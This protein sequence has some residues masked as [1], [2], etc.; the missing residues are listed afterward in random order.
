MRVLCPQCSAEYEV[1]GAALAGRSRRLRCAACGEEWRTAA[2]LRES[3]APESLAPESLAP[4]SLTPESLAPESLG[5]A[6]PAP[7]LPVQPGPD[8][9]HWMQPP[10]WPAAP[11]PPALGAAGDEPRRFGEPMD[12]AAQAE[13]QQAVVAEAAPHLADEPLP[14]FLTAARNP[15]TQPAAPASAGPDGFAE[16]VD[17]ARR[18]QMQMEPEQNTKTG[19]RRASNKVLVVLLLVALLLALAV[20]ERHHIVHLLPGSARLFR[21]LGLQ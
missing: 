5:A 21:A 6:D 4:E 14:M 8:A 17:A 10:A 15:Y 18:K 3:H 11:A 20:V 9:P 7:S 13:I 19:I 16:L 1:P 12:D 2:P